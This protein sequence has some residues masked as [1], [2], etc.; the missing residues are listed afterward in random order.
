MSTGQDAN[1]LHQGVEEPGVEARD[2]VGSMALSLSNRLMLLVQQPWHVLFNEQDTVAGSARVT[3]VVVAQPTCKVVCLHAW[4][5]A[6]RR[7][8]KHCGNHG[9][10]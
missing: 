6:L 10:V 7:P 8:P 5:A 9:P 1:H 2:A 3:R 4:H